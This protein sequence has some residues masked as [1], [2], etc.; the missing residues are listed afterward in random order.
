VAVSQAMDRWSR[1]V[2]SAVTPGFPELPD[3]A[4]ARVV[5]AFE[6]WLLPY[7]QGT[8]AICTGIEL[9]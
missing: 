3:C 4:A 2:E 6:S 9:Q 7:V 5:W 8:Y 1:W